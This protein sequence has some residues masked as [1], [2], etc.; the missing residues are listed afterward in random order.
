MFGLS[1]AD[2]QSQQNAGI[3]AQALSMAQLDPMQRGIYDIYAGA[4]KLAGVGAGMLGMVNPKIEDAKQREE[5]AKGVDWNDPSS[6]RLA[7]YKIAQTNPE[8]AM[9]LAD[10]A[11]ARQKELQAE[12][13]QKAQEEKAGVHP[14][15]TTQEADPNNPS[16]TMTVNW[17]FDKNVGDYVRQERGVSQKFATNPPKALSAG[18]RANAA[19]DDATV[20]WIAKQRLAGNKDAGG[21]FGRSP[22]INARISKRMREISEQAGMSPE[23]VNTS[24]ANWQSLVSGA[25]ST[26]ISNAQMQGASIEA[27]KLIAQARDAYKSLDPTS[28]P[29]LNSIL[30]WVGTEKD[31]PK[32][33]YL[34]TKLNGVVNTYARAINPKGVST[35]DSQKEARELLQMRFG[36]LSADAALTAM[37]EEMDAAVTSPNETRAKINQY[38][39]DNLKSNK[40][41]TNQ[42]QTIAGIPPNSRLIGKTPQGKDVYQSPDGKKWVH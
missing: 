12:A 5:A 10:K 21:T 24:V 15:I 29:S 13:L 8:M 33:A 27:N 20:D 26:G 4:G 11:N 34:R 6:I 42:S 7:A 3:N 2:I 28:F 17:I 35:V 37:T 9:A 36:A 30:N 18:E 25:K 32:I 40:Q 1:P 22:E 19:M 23:D 41:A 16:Q 38:Y 39:I 31:N 14:P